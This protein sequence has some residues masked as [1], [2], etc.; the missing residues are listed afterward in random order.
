[1]A[2]SAHARASVAQR[3]GITDTACGMDWLE[4]HIS[5]AG[6]VVAAWLDSVLRGYDAARTW[7]LCWKRGILSEGQG[8]AG[9]L[10][11]V[12]QERA[13]EQGGV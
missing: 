13:Q 3:V 5:F 10:R 12:R 9:A 7:L 6:I 8:N 4:R 2:D 1:M 11:R